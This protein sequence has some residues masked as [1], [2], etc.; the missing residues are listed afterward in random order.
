[1]KQYNAIIRLPSYL[2]PIT[3]YLLPTMFRLE[4]THLLWRKNR[5]HDYQ[6]SAELKNETIKKISRQK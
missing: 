5:F 3:Y 2:L 6:P 4:Y 1:M